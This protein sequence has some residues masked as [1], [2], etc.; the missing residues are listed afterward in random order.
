MI[1]KRARELGIPLTGTT[2]KNNAITDVCGIEVG[3]S[4]VIYGTPDDYTGQGSA[5]ARTGVTAILPRG[6]QRSAVFVGRHDLNGNGELTGT[7]W[8][9]DSGLMHGPVL[10]MNNMIQKMILRHYE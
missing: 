5:F 9:D 2:G 8:L 3:Y 6:K 1:K 7:Y 10:I 4:T